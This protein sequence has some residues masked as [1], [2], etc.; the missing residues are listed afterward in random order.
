MLL[1]L[2]ALQ[3]PTEQFLKRVSL[4]LS[5]VGG[6]GETADLAAG[7]FCRD[8]TLRSGC[9]NNRDR[10]V[11]LICRV[12]L[13]IT[14]FTECANGVFNFGTTGAIAFSSGDR[15]TNTFNG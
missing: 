6:F 12:G 15:L 5:A 3:E 14:G 4:C 8:E 10:V 9:G 1:S 7:T 13:G 2:K 11:K